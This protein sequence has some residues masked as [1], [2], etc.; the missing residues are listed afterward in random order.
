MPNEGGNGGTATLHTTTTGVDPASVAELVGGGRTVAATSIAVDAGK[1]IADIVFVLDGVPPGSYDLRLTQP[2]GSVLTKVAAFAVTAGGSPELSAQIIGRP[3]IRTGKPAAFEVTVLNSG[4]VDALLVPLWISLPSQVAVSIDGLNVPAGSTNN[5]VVLAD[6]RYYFFQLL[7]KVAAHQSVSI[8]F[9]VTAPTDLPSIPMRA[10]LQAPWARTPA[11]ATRIADAAPTS[12]PACVPDA[13]N[14]AFIDCSSLV[15]A[16]LAVGERPLADV[17]APPPA[18]GIGVHPL[19]AGRQVA[20]DLCDDSKSA[21]DKGFEAGKN[22]AKNKTDTKNPYPWGAD[23]INWNIGHQTGVYTANPGGTS[24]GRARA[25]AALDG[26]QKPQGEASCPVNKPLPP[27]PPPVPPGGGGGSGSGGSIDPNDKFGPTG[28][29]SAAH[30]FRPA[31]M[32]YEIA[33]EN[34]PTAS[35]PAADVVVTDRLDPSKVDLATLSLGDIRFG[36]HTISVPPGLKSFSTVYAISA[37]LAVRVQGSL[38]PATGLLKWTFTTLDPLTKLPPSDPTL[39]FLPPD[40]DGISGQGFVGF[41]VSPKAG[42]ANGTTI[43]NQA[44]IVFDANPAIL[45]PT[46][47]NT[48]DTTP[49]SSRVQTLTGRVGTM[50]FDVVWSGTDTGSGVGAY[51]VYV[52][53]NGGPFVAWQTAVKATSGVYTGTSGHSYAFYAR[54][55]DGAG[56]AEATK[57]A[58][59]ATIA[60]DGTFA[61]PSSG[62]SGGGGCTIGGDDQR[63]ASLPLFIMAAWL[64]VIARRRRAMSLRRVRH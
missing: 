34:Q 1:T 38:D 60:V 33:F 31:A 42:L 15:L 39:G 62:S 49:S 27:P 29:G 47:I 35:L 13:V 51:T 48:I 41:T 64:L 6:G 56:N 30:F 14:A 43:T 9:T 59:E 50:D 63:D 5:S 55:N 44:S 11:A 61:A 23:N 52:S 45:T 2:D 36:T 57:A 12:S 16:Y 21:F 53:D 22:D 26:R 10:V 18:T 20:L 3:K 32:R 28:D 7:A 37:T 25:Q 17:A 8:P 46:W 4:S 19:A 58:A 40:T 54:S 24:A